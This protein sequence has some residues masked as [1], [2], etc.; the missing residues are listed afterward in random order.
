MSRL[1]EDTRD[2]VSRIDETR[3]W[4]RHMEMA[5]IGAIPN[6]GVN[7]AAFSRE[8]IAAR[9]L[10]IS[11]ARA[12]NFTVAIDAI[13]N[14]FIRR[15]GTDANAPPEYPITPTGVLMPSSPASLKFRVARIAS[16]TLWPALAPTPH[17]DC[18]PS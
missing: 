9:K 5:Q 12:R 2:A 10:L 4:Q 13:G 16:S 7:R 11:W 17:S 18:G 15:A 6:N 3:L 1:R 8:D 14:L